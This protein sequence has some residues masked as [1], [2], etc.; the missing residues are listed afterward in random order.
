M[1]RFLHSIHDASDAGMNRVRIGLRARVRVQATLEMRPQS[2]RAELRLIAD[3]RRRRDELLPDM[4]LFSFAS[5]SRS[6]RS[7]R[8]IL[9]IVPT[10]RTPDES[11]D[12][13]VDL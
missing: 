7:G 11:V 2:A 12:V 6:N 1:A 5:V 10:A 3:I 4:P 13:E 8:F 9:A